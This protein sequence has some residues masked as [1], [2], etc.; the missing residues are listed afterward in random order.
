MRQQQTFAHCSE[1]N[2]LVKWNPGFN[3]HIKRLLSYLTLQLLLTL[4][5]LMIALMFCSSEALSLIQFKYLIKLDICNNAAASYGV[6]QKH[7]HYFQE[8]FCQRAT[9]FMIV[10][11]GYQ[12]SFFLFCFTRTSLYLLKQAKANLKFTR[13]SRLS[14]LTK[15]QFKD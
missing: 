3:I 9:R 5:V 6:Q 4:S 12:L 13:R 2:S 1:K 8:I 7:F 14:L 11:C 10:T 15:L